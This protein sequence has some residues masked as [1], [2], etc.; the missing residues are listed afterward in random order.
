MRL[1][2][3]Y[4]CLCLLGAALPFSQLLPWLSLH[5]LNFKLF[6]AEL[7]STRIGGFF[8]L[9]VIVSV[10][11]LFIFIA[12]EGKRLAIQKIWVQMV[13]TLAGVFRL[14]FRFSYLCD[15]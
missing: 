1:R 7:F 13:A 8:G 10:L 11:V 6:F 4:V 5:G 3:L 14:A 15:N 2:N 9:D 12:V